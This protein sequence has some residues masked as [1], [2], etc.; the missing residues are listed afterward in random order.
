MYDEIAQQFYKEPICAM[1]LMG[2]HARGE[3]QPYSD[4]D[5]VCITNAD[6]APE[7]ETYYIDNQLVVVS[8]VTIDQTEGWFTEPKQVVEVIANLREANILIDEHDIYAQLKQ[9]AKHFQWTDEHQQKMN[10]YVG[11]ELVGLIEEVHKGLNCLAQYHVGRLINANHGLAWG[12]TYIMLVYHGVLASGDN[13]L[14]EGVEQA[15]GYDSQWSQLHRLSYGI[16]DPEET[17]LTLK[18]RLIASL[19]LYKLTYAHCQSACNQGQQQLINKTIS[20]IHDVVA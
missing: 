18:D 11:G 12:L 8:Y 14:I 16:A 19:K 3:A 4:I 17:K 10:T 5:L 1:A 13:G 7:P 15:V 6:H 9:R 20:F 2:S